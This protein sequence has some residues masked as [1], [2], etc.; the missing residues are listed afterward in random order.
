MQV[1]RVKNIV[2]I[3]LIL[4]GGHITA[5][6]YYS[7]ESAANVMKR[8]SFC[9]RGIKSS[10]SDAKPTT[11]D[12]LPR[13]S[14]DRHVSSLIGCGNNRCADSSSGCCCNGGRADSDWCNLGAQWKLFGRNDQ[15]RIAAGG[16]FQTGYHSYNTGQFNNRPY[17]FDVHQAW[18]WIE[19][20]ADNDGYGFDWGF[21][22]DGVYGTDGP[23]T[24]AFGNNSGV[25]DEDW[26]R[27]G[28][29]GWAIPQAYLQAQYND[30]EVII[31]HFFTL[32][33][34]EVVTAP[35]NFFYS[36]SFTM[37][38]SEPFTHTGVL[39]TYNGI[40]RLTLY[41]GYTFGWDTGF[42]RNEGDTFIGGASLQLSDRITATYIALFG[43]QGFG[44]SN[45]RGYNHSFVLDVDVTDHLKYVFQTDYVDYSDGNPFSAAIGNITR[46]RGI[47]QYLFYQVND[48][49]GLGVRVEWWNVQSDVVNR[50]DLYE[51]T[52]GANIKP[53]ANITLRPEFRWDRDDE[54][55][56]IPTAHNNRIGFGLDAI[57][58]F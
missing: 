24:Q 11:C 46:S 27:G 50:S 12:A 31:G 6:D 13:T 39:S 7:H 34:Y 4:T 42:D 41:S 51:I 32:V 14:A 33:G 1:V 23:D 47:N 5:Q 15:S 53:H 25:F 20:T 2:T 28:F 58:L 17:N 16:W 56:L 54:G 8:G 10:L 57:F 44:V 18:L 37:Y 48:C 40:E 43:T 35:D 55:V 26:D 36:H 29:H 19:R 30:W 52:V 22:V 38:N 3:C 49:L 9:D 21:R 45:K